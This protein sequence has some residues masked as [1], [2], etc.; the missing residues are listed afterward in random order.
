MT[1]RAC[2]TVAVLAALV[3]ASAS[4]AEWTSAYPGV[5]PIVETRVPAQ[6]DMAIA[7]WAK[8]GVTG[9]PD[10]IRAFWADS[11]S[12]PDA[13]GTAPGGRGWNCVIAL[14]VT[15]V[16]DVRESLQSKDSVYPPENSFFECTLIFHEVGHALGLTHTASGLMTGTGVWDETSYPNECKELA[17]PHRPRAHRSPRRPLN[18]HTGR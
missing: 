8:R 3:P 6:V 15:Q 1:S 5:R 9:C 2:A 10:G 7:F 4:A 12:G 16:R 13:I 11:L 14:D 17:R 18:Q